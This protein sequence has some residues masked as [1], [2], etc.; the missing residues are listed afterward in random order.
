MLWTGFSNML[1]QDH[2]LRR[3]IGVKQVNEGGP[4]PEQLRKDLEAQGRNYDLTLDFANK[5]HGVATRWINRQWILVLRWWDLSWQVQQRWN[6]G[7]SNP[8][9]GWSPHK[10]WDFGKEKGDW[11][12]FGRTRFGVLIY[13]VIFCSIA[14]NSIILIVTFPFAPVMVSLGPLGIT[15]T[16]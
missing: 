11:G 3:F 13:S 4:S 14:L 12:S 8:I 1:D 9:S 16:F 10:R 6:G 5:A 7:F 15:A 2:Y